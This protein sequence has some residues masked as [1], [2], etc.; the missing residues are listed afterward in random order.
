MPLL[1]ASPFDLL[2]SDPKIKESMDSTRRHAILLY[3]LLNCRSQASFSASAA[4]TNNNDDATSHHR[5]SSS[6]SIEDDYPPIEPESGETTTATTTCSIWTKLPPVSKDFE[7]QHEALKRPL[8][9]YLSAYNHHYLS[10]NLSSTFRILFPNIQRH[11]PP[12]SSSSSSSSTSGE[13]VPSPTNTTVTT[14]TRNEIERSFLL[15]R[16]DLIKT[17]SIP[18]PRLSIVASLGSSK[19]ARLYRFELYGVSW[20]CDLDQAVEFLELHGEQFGTI[21]EL[22][23]AG[24]NDVRQLQKPSLAPIV[25]TIRHPKV[26]DLSRYKEAT[27]DLNLF[28]IQN[29]SGLEKLLFDLDYV[30]PPPPESVPAPTTTAATVVPS[31]V[32]PAPT[33]SSMTKLMTNFQLRSPSPTDAQ[34]YVSQDNDD[35]DEDDNHTLA[36]IRQCKSLTHLQMGIQSADAFAWAVKWSSSPKQKRLPPLKVLNLSSNKTEIL[37]TALEDGLLAFQDT[38]ESVKAVAIK[39]YMVME[40]SSLPPTFGWSWNLNRLKS[41]SLRGEIAAWFELESLRYC[42][43]L[44]DLNLTL[45]PYTP[46][47]PDHLDKVSRLAPQLSSL[48]I[49]GRWFLSDAFLM[50]L[51]LGLPKL[52]R[53]CLDGC[54]A[55]DL[56]TDGLTNGLETMT[57]LDELEIDLGAG[58]NTAAKVHLNHMRPSV[59]FSEWNQFMAEQK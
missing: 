45:H 9:D 43:A 10:L 34:P 11:S 32:A 38:L 47:R 41:L 58:F 27:R 2:E 21:K 39:L 28:E 25:R 20:Y 44:Q 1:Y 7:T 19:F 42:P 31:M 33:L 46:P 52:T 3:L 15:H 26:L 29:L 17:L 40:P 12:P 13:R 22:K 16:P 36:K 6:T 51:S 55:D 24:P 23:I 54:Q 59:K 18:I 48:A 35:Q 5:L 53:F 50:Q 37:K 4:F 56:T 8:V 14:F 49:V 30:P 57:A